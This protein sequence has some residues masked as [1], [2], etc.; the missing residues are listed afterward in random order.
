M[1]HL[2]TTDRSGKRRSVVPKRFSSNLFRNSTHLK[3]SQGAQVSQNRFH[4]NE[5]TLIDNVPPHS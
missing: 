4:S 1:A 5:Q 3:R 2:L